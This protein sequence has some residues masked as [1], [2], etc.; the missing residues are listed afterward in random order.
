MLI[1]SFLLFI[2]PLEA[3]LNIMTRFSNLLRLF[4]VTAWRRFSNLGSTVGIRRRRG[5]SDTVVVGSSLPS[6]SG[7]TFKAIAVPL[8]RRFL[9]RIRSV[10]DDED[11][12]DDGT[13]GADGEVDIGTDV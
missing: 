5:S 6:L 10:D 13:C 11:E 2:I 9:P 7:A 3:L 1:L 12:E 8:R 4:A